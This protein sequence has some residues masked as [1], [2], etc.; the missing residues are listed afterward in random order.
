MKTDSK[1]LF[2]KAYTD[3]TARGATDLPGIGDRAFVAGGDGH[4][5]L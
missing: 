2:D 5:T 4:S 3:A 1:A